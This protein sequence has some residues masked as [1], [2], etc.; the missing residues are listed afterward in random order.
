MYEIFEVPKEHLRKAK[1]ILKDDV[2]S[3]QSIV[4]RDA[5]ALDLESNNYYILIEG[6]EEGLTRAR[7]LFT[8]ARILEGRE[9]EEIYGKIKAGE[10]SS[11]SGIGMIFD[12]F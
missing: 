3:R 6:N 2:I 11:A 8:M 5:V 10:E 7:E 12:G 1:E 4:E 9:K